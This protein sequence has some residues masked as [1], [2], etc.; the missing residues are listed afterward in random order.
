MTIQSPTWLLTLRT[1]V[2]FPQNPMVLVFPL[3]AELMMFVVFGTLFKS[4]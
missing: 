4:V 2:Q 1:L 3:A